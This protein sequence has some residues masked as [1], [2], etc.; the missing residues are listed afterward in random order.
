REVPKLWPRSGANRGIKA[1]AE[2]KAKGGLGRPVSHPEHGDTP[3]DDSLNSE[4]PV[5]AEP[6]VARI[7]L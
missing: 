5:S 4:K 3:S 7:D 2:R 6:G 1:V